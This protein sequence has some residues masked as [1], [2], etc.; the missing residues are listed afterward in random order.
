MVRFVFNGS[1]YLK[2]RA[3]QVR[4]GAD[5]A[6]P[7]RAMETRDEDD[8]KTALAELETQHRDLD[9]AIIAMSQAGSFTQLQIQRLKK[10]KL[11]LKDEI[12]KIRAVL[13]PDIIA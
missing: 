13:I 4:F 9:D 7:S 10:R 1:I 2:H 6:T 8:L 3:M 12:A 11:A 5:E